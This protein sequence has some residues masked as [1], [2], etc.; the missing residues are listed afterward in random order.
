MLAWSIPGGTLSVV[1]IAVYE[2]LRQRR[3]K[4]AGTPLATTTVNEITAMFYGS[5][6]MELDHRDSVAVM[7]EE[8]A[9]GAPPL[10]VDLD[11][12]VVRLSPHHSMAPLPGSDAARLHDVVGTPGDDVDGDRHRGRAQDAAQDDEHDRLP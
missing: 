10:A 5:K 4:R 2:L 7:R 1:G 11:H 9:Q 3:R 8:D 6:R 12:G